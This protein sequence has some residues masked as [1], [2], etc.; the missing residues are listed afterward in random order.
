MGVIGSSAPAANLPS[1]TAAHPVQDLGW[2]G[3]VETGARFKRPKLAAIE[4]YRKDRILDV[5][6]FDV[7]LRRLRA[8]GREGLD[9]ELDVDETISATAR[10]AG[11]LEVVVR[12]PRRSNIRVL[13]LMDVGGTMD[14][15]TRQVEQLFT[16]ANRATHFKE[17]QAYYFHN[18]VYDEVYLDAQFRRSILVDDLLKKQRPSTKLIVVGDAMMAPYELIA[19]KG[20]YF[21]GHRSQKSGIEQLQTLSDFFDKAAWLNPENPR[22]WSGRTLHEIKKLFPM[23]ALTLEGLELAIRHLVGGPSRKAL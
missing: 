10:N 7:A 16:A 17:F 14:P 8:F 15:F 9:L 23:W 4:N 21:F 3:R 6:Q 5:R 1:V 20:A 2:E 19:P 22:Y 13:L 18:C 12:P 11:E